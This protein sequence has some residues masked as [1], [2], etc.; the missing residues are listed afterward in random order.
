MPFWLYFNQLGGIN[1]KAGWNN[2]AIMRLRT[3][4]RDGKREAETKKALESR[5]NVDTESY[6]KKGGVIERLPPCRC[7]I[8]ALT[9]KPFTTR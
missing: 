9:N 6:L 5:L 1:V 3:F 4:R 7:N 8:D 2:E